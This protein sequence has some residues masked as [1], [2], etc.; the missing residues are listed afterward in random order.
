M[1]TVKGTSSLA[2]VVAL[3]FF[4]SI[5]PVVAVGQSAQ[6]T[7]SGVADIQLSYKR[8]SRQVDP[9]RGIGPWATGP[10]Y[11]GATAQDTVETVARAVD[12]KGQ[13][14]GVSLEWTPSDPEM[15]TVAPGQGDH[16]KITVHKVGES[17]LKIS[18]QGFSKELVVKATSTGKFLVFQIAPHIPS[19]PTGPS[20]M[21]MSPALKDRKA[22]ISYAAGMRMA[23]TLHKQSVEADPDLVKQAI[24]DVTSGGPTL[25][26]DDQVQ[27]VLLGVET[28]LNVT[29]AT[30][31]RKKIAEKNKQLGEQF[32]AK[33]K[34]KDGVVT[35]PSGLQYRV[36]KAGDGKKPTILDAAVCQYKGSLLD[37]T[38]FDNSYKRKDG[39]PVI[40]PVRGVIRGWQEALKLMPAGSKWQLFVPADLAYGERGM[41]MAKIP[42]NSTLVFEV[43]LLSVK[44][45]AQKG[46]Q[47]AA[48]PETTV[49]PQQLDAVE[50]AMQAAKKESEKEAETEREKNQ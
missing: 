22:Q 6:G 21:E 41:P 32:L 33:N 10:S 48:S 20:A 9:F 7:A 12:A 43:E 47:V 2:A 50:K 24:Q 27:A 8:D 40:F 14:I 38:E 44:E 31:E 13:P 18:T 28:E 19:K 39:K 26:T 15:V 45:P 23:K 5:F 36:L 35:L 30:L 1:I 42:P 25:M 11:T 3:L 4:L 37:G 16:V 34:E 49:T 46:S 29:E 17:Q